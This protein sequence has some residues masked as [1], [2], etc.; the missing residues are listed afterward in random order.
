MPGEWDTF[1]KRKIR[2]SGKDLCWTNSYSASKCVIN[3]QSLEPPA[4][5]TRK[6]KVFLPRLQH[7]SGKNHAHSEGFPRQST[8]LLIIRSDKVLSLPRVSCLFMGKISIK[9]LCAAHPWTPMYQLELPYHFCPCDSADTHI[10]QMSKP[11]GIWE[12]VKSADWEPR[13]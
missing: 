1:L 10:G 5:P 13:V 4:P 7:L 11:K 3:N 8:S 2:N 12:E 6:K 9:S